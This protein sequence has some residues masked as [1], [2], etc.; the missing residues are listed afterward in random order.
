MKKQKQ[1][2]E[3]QKDSKID[4]MVKKLISVDPKLP[5]WEQETPL[6]NRWHPDI[7]SVASVEEGEVFR[8]E[9]KI[10]KNTLCEMCF[11]FF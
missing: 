9:C 3:Q 7:P 5:P 8:V 6:H 11:I 1:Q 2:Q 4:I 10:S